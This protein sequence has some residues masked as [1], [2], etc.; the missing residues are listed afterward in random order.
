MFGLPFRKWGTAV[1]A[2]HFCLGKPVAKEGNL[3]PD[4]QANAEDWGKG[5]N[6]CEDAG[7]LLIWAVS[8]AKSTTYRRFLFRRHTDCFQEATC[9]LQ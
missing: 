5:G 2:W 6:Q 9:Q 8:R 7:P 4:Q 1:F 3:F